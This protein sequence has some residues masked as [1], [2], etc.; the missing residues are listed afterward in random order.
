M[1]SRSLFLSTLL[2][3]AQESTRYHHLNAAEAYVSF[4]YVSLTTWVH[5]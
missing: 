5:L 1:L 4:S 2:Q 3:Y